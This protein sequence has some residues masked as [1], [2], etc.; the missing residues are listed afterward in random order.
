MKSEERHLLERTAIMLE[1][2]TDAADRRTW[3]ILNSGWSKDTT[4][5]LRRAARIVRKV[6]EDDVI[7]RRGAVTTPHGGIQ[8][9]TTPR[10]LARVE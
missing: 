1:E 7:Q 4:K 3:G 2:A 5:A 6:I 10:L 9:D 8:S